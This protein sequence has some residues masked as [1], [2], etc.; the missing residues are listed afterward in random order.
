MKIKLEKI[1]ARALQEGPF[2]TMDVS[3]L[4]ISRPERPSIVRKTSLKIKGVIW[5]SLVRWIRIRMARKPMMIYLMIT[6]W[7]NAISLKKGIQLN[8]KLFF[9]KI[10]IIY[11]YLILVNATLHNVIMEK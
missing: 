2:L 5:K 9:F 3:D 11:L 10:C 6:I 7:T 1:G 8:S 4:E